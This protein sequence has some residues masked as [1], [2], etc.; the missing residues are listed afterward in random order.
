MAKRESVKLKEA[1]DYFKN[2]RKELLKHEDKIA[3]I[4]DT[5][6]YKKHYRRLTK[7]KTQGKIDCAP[8]SKN[9]YQIPI[10]QEELIEK[11]MEMGDEEEYEAIDWLFG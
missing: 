8:C 6:E 5:E 10:I 4:K 2:V 1:I 11:I 7:A 9:R 3:A